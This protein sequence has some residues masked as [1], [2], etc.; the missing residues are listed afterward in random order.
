MNKIS[1]V[2][3]TYNEEKNI[4]R[5]L[6][7]IKNLTDDIVILDSFS[8]DKT[9]EI[10]KEYNVN[11]IKQSFLG[12]I[13]QK[14]KAISYAKND[15]ILSLDADEAV[16]EELSLNIK[17]CLSNFNV[18]G[19]YIN[20]LTNYCGKW[21][22]H[23]G[24]YPDKKLR[25][26]NSK[27]GKW[28]GINPHDKYEL[29]KNSKTSTLKGDLYHFSYYTYEDHLKQLN[30]FTSILANQYIEKGKSVNNLQLIINPIFKFIKY[31][32]IKLGFLDGWEGYII[33][34]TSA[35]ATFI[36]YAKI[37]GYIKY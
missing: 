13:E 8:T 2:I 10:A 32:F 18:D 33:A 16:S 12:H 1:V 15:I 28:S 31:Y 26:F 19:Y 20:R 27:K 17:N 5:C 11:F 29:N 25:L 23:G 34:K 6:E 7:S 14:N 9:E 4:R 37:K 24:W 30:S 35:F 22:K 36:K 3:I 21:I